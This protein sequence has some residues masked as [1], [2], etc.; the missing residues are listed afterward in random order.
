MTQ[1]LKNS[2]EAKAAIIEAQEDLYFFTRY[3]FS[4]RKKYK[5]HRNWHHEK[6]CEALMKVYRGEI[7][8][9]IINM[10]PRYS[11]T[12]IAV[13]N[14]VAWAMGKH[15]DAEFI[16]A[17]YAHTL[18]AKN[19]K[20]IRSLV[21]H[22]E[23]RN[24]FPEL[25]LKPDSKSADNWETTAD[26]TFYASGAEGTITG[27]GAGK[28]RPEFGGA[29]IIDDPHKAQQARS[30][31]RRQNVIDWYTD[32]IADRVNSKHTPIILIMQRLEEQDLTG[33]LKA[34]GS[35]E[36]WEV[37]EFQAIQNEGQV[38]E[39]A[40]WEHKHTL[41]MLKSMEQAKPYVFAGQYQQRPAPLKGGFFKPDMI[42]V[43][44][45]IPEGEEIKW[46]R[47]W[48]L[49]ATSGAGDW[50]VG[51][52]IGQ[53][54]DK[55]VIIADVVRIQGDAHEVEATIVNTAGRDGTDVSIHLN[56]DPGQ[57]GK[58]Q[59]QYL[60]AKLSGYSV[61]SEI[62]SGDK[63]TRAL[64]FAAQVN[65][66]NVMMLK[67]PWNQEVV[68]EFRVFPNGKH[69]DQVDACSGGF[70][71]LSTPLPGEGMFEYYRQQAEAKNNKEQE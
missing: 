71:H 69:D 68:N 40:L 37:V 43:V 48:D 60:T 38:T 16:H 18:A 33:F 64:P 55:R 63:A 61:I 52:K 17:S 23:Y 22:P 47:K 25:A 14:F 20:Q 2:E 59:A 3:M 50:T 29:I 62:E 8:R 26:G 54:R 56:Q 12:E 19:S 6:I 7:T 30:K 13:V 39:A 67:A 28:D 70:N 34:G 9:L 32:T 58:A 53:L 45:A 5:W 36:T 49:A 51:A 21:Q 11:K 10:P 42:K 57:A 41:K 66:G 46:I 4:K 15:P 65:V 35:G 31:V 24:I 44:E 27:F 1:S